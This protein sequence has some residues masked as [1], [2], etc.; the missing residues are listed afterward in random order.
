[1]ASNSIGLP[2]LN[3]AELYTK[4]YY[5]QTLLQAD[6]LNQYAQA[7][8]SSNNVDSVDL[9]N[10]IDVGGSGSATQKAKL[11]QK[12]A[13][14]EELQEEESQEED[15]ISQFI[16]SCAKAIKLGG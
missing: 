10:R 2:G 13:N 9:S 6:P 12:Q 11:D 14:P 5:A 1:V 7:F 15:P 4:R 16:N 3:A 8:G